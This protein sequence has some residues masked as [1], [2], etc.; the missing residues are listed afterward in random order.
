[1]MQSGK[2]V[3]RFRYIDFAADMRRN[4]YDVGIRKRR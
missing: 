2:L 3:D 1:M 4:W